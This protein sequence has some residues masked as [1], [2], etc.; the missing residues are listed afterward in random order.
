MTTPM[1]AFLK[2][3]HYSLWLGILGIYLFST[4]LIA[5]FEFKS[6]IQG[7][8]PATPTANNPSVDHIYH[9]SKK[10]IFFRSMHY[11]IANLVQMDSG[12][13][14]RNVF[15][16]CQT[17]LLWL[18]SLV[19]IALFTSNMVQYFTAE[20]E[21]PWIQSIEDL[22][23]CGTIGCSRIGILER[24]QHADYFI[25]E[26][27]HDIEVNYYRLKHPTE[28]YTKLLDYHIDVAIA[29]SSSADY[30]T[31]TDYC[32]LEVAGL[33]F[34]RTEF[35]IAVPKNW[36]YKDQLDRAIIELKESRAIDDL[37]SKW[38]QQ[39]HCD[40]KNK[41]QNDVFGDGLTL[42]GARGLFIVFIGFTSINILLFICQ[43]VLPFN[44]RQW[45][46]FE[47]LSTSPSN[48][49]FIHRDTI[50]TNFSDDKESAEP[51][52][53]KRTGSVSINTPQKLDEQKERPN[54]K[55]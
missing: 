15:G 5:I 49:Q 23:M 29:D 46:C 37:F 41:I 35:A 22:K 52:R 24:S 16:C 17:I 31:Q 1:M 33:P 44:A 2:P 6:G 39:K 8:T 51:I 12:L 42:E 21:K 48:E 43:Q 53:D 13:Q 14:T 10:T 47:F 4:I 7:V 27:T 34:S 54:T 11:T 26:V 36:T 25:K 28:I 50:L 9:E 38:F 20:R 19:L 40:R 18:I 3:F 32:D 55:E 30:L 45:K